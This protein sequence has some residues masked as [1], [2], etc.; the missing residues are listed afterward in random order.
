MANIQEI[1]FIPAR[2][3]RKFAMKTSTKFSRR[4]ILKTG[5]QAPLAASL[6]VAVTACGGRQEKASVCVDLES[7][8]LGEKGS[9]SALDYTETSAFSDKN[10]LYCAY[11]TP[12]SSGGDAQAAACGECSIFQG[13]ANKNGY[14][15][16]WSIKDNA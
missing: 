1:Q 16:S 8:S 13:P 11:F 5:V 2:E 15:N 7:L 3:A 6:A 12:A 4:S 9:R 14:C 10:C